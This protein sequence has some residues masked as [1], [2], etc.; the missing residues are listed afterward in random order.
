MINQFNKHIG[1]FCKKRNSIVKDNLYMSVLVYFITLFIIDYSGVL[2]LYGQ[3]IVRRC[4]NMYRRTDPLSYEKKIKPFCIKYERILNNN[5]INR[6]KSIKLPN[7][8]DFS[9]VSRKNTTTHQCCDKYSKNEKA[10]MKD[11][12]EKLRIKYQNKIGKKLYN[13]KSNTAT[14]YRYHGNKSKHLWHLDPNNITDIYNVIICIG[15]KGNISPLQCKDI[16]DRAYSIH[17][18]EGWCIIWRRNYSTSIPPKT[19]LIRKEQ[20]YRLPL[21]L[22]KNF[23]KVKNSV[24]TYAPIQKVAITILML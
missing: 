7:N 6:L 1:R 9:L 13:F 21:Q 20:F 8:T 17:F 22:I 12:M 18:N 16:S 2:D 11:I 14:I 24:K 4:I 10:I 15:K 5:D 3:S 19:I 23:L